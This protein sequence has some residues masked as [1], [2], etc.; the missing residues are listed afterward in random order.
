[1]SRTTCYCKKL[2]EQYNVKITG[3]KIVYD[4]QTADETICLQIQAYDLPDYVRNVIDQYF[5]SRE[6][7]DKEES[8]T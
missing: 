4:V 2:E 8:H 7:N 3:Y 1:M 5:D 6:K